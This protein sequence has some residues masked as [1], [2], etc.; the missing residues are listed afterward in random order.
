MYVRMYFD[1]L[2]VFVIKF[3]LLFKLAL[4]IY[5]VDDI[6]RYVK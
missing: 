3:S 2:V 1:A 4:A 5:C 6:V